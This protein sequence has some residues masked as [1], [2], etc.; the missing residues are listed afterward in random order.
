MTQEEFR[1]KIQEGCK[2]STTYCSKCNK[3]Y[4]GCL[5]RGLQELLGNINR[6]KV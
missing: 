1:Q 2:K 6:T 3:S 4:N 5:S